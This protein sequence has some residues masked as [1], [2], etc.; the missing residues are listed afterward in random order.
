VGFPTVGS[1]LSNFYG[2]NF[3][4]NGREEVFHMS[5]PFR[6]TS[7]GADGDTDEVGD[8]SHSSVGYSIG[9]NIPVTVSPT[10][11]A[12]STILSTLPLSTSQAPVEVSSMNIASSTIQGPPNPTHNAPSANSGTST[13]VESEPMS[14]STTVSIDPQITGRNRRP[15]LDGGMIAGIV[16]GGVSALIAFSGLIG[17]VLYYRW[18]LLGKT[19]S[20]RFEGSRSLKVDGK[21][22]KAELDAEELE[23]K[24][25]RVHELQATREIQELDGRM[26]PAELPV[27]GF[28]RDSVRTSV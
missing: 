9:S 13:S 6:I 4:Q 28:G 14:K 26:R 22:R 27:V 3:S 10:N 24:I 19:I 12:S 11:I 18:R 23:F 8:D 17:L 25:T 15:I 2:L 5:P 20:S 21:F 1:Q 16:T 7:V